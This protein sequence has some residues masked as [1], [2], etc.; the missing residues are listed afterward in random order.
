M[1]KEVLEVCKLETLAESEGYSSVDEM[2][3]SRG[4]DSTVPAI[5]MNAG[6]DYTTDME[7]DQSEGYCGS[8]NTNTVK[9]CL[10]LAGV[11]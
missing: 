3:E 4:L 6:C 8:C 10:V 7:P 5:C 11:I 2:L 9:S 1:R